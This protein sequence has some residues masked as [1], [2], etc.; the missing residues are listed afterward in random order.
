MPQPT[1]YRVLSQTD[2]A[3]SQHR[4][5]YETSDE[6]TSSSLDSLDLVLVEL[7]NK[8]KKRRKR[9]R[10]MSGVQ[11]F[12]GAE[13]YEVSDPIIMVECQFFETGFERYSLA[14]RAT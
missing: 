6:L 3:E 8:R 13:S 11:K 2:E 5:L 9:R 7:G 1:S 4:S 10:K 12:D 14:E